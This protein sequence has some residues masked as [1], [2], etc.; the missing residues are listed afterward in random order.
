V[1]GAVAPG[2]LELEYD[3]TRGVGFHALVGQRRA[4]DVAAQLPRAG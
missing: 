3:L 2:C 1:R 4:R